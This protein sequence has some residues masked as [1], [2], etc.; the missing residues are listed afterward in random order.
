LVYHIQERT[1]AEEYLD[2][3]GQGAGGWRKLHYEELQAVLFTKYHQ[4]NKGKDEMDGACRMYET[5]KNWN[6]QTTCVILKPQI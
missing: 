3:K 1:Y 6:V 2:L 5:D 4:N